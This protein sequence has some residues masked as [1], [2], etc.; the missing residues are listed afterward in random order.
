MHVGVTD[1]VPAPHDIEA[2]ALPSGARITALN[3]H[4]E[5]Q[6][7]RD[8]LQ[9]LDALLVWHAPIT[10]SVASSLERCKIIVRYGVGYDNIDLVAMR[11][12]SI[13]FCNT[14]DYGTEEVADTAAAMI[15]T[16]QRK[17][18]QY[19]RYSRGITTGWQEHV[20]PPISR[21]NSCTL[22]LVGV[23][24]IGT[25]LANRLKPF[26]YRIVGYD[27]Y[28]PSGHEKAVGYERCYQLSDLLAQ[29]DIVS[30][31]CPLNDETRGMV[32]QEFIASMKP[33]AVL[34]NTAR[35][36]L[37]KHLD[38]VEEGLRSNHLSAVSLDVLPEEPPPSHQL[39]EDWRTDR[40]WLQ[41]RLI[42]NP[43]S[44]YY[45]TQAWQEMRYK[46]AETITLFTESGV[47]RNRIA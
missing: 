40:E 23:G 3:V 41:G 30:L 39:L 6:F 15:L 4:E 43:H 13:P 16:M 37:L 21:T 47:L 34:V 42:I 29:S 2:S 20:L 35:G 36:G 22:G 19:D 14:P 38:V 26:G 27:P 7:D 46:A 18:L 1:Y 25:A 12:H 10:Q 8:L 32:G 45:S 31:H 24:R 28:Q 11:D 9:D 5:N 17:I 44:A 33:G